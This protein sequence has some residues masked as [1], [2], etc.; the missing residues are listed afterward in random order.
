ML[1]GLETVSLGKRQ[2]SELEV[3]ELK[4]LSPRK[5]QRYMM[6]EKVTEI[7]EATERSQALKTRSIASASTNR[8]RSSSASIVAAKTCAKLEAVRAKAEFLKKESEILIEKARLKVTE[9][10][11][12]ASLSALKHESEVAAALAEAKVLE[13]AAESELGERISDVRE[14]S[15]RTHDY[16][17]CQSQVELS[18]PVGDEPYQSP[19]EPIVH[20]LKPETPQRQ[21]SLYRLGCNPDTGLRKAWERLEDCFGSPEIIEKSLFDR[22][23]SFPKISNKDA[24]KLRELR[25]LL[26]EVESAKRKGYNIFDRDHDEMAPPLREGQECWYLPIFGVYHPQKPGQ[27]RVVFDSSVQKQGISLNDVLLSG[28]DLNNSLLGVLLRFRRE[29]VAVT[30]DIEQMFHSFIVKEEDRDF[31]HFLWF[32]ENDTRKEIIEYCM[33]AH[34]FG[35][36][37]SPA[38]AIYGLRQAAAYDEKEYGSDAKHFVEREFYVDDGLLSTPTAAEAIDL[39]TRT[40]EMLA[41]LNLRLHKFASNSKE[42]MDAFP[43]KDHA[44]GLKDLNLEV[45]PTPI[46]C[47]LGLSSD[48]KRDVFTFHVTNIKKPFTRRGILATVNS[49]F[50]PIGFVAPS[51]L[52]GNSYYEN[53]QVRLLTGTLLS[54]KI[55]KK[56]GM[57]GEN[58]YKISNGWKFPDRMSILP[59][60][61]L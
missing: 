14:I 9:A 51:S 29:L 23:D 12:E 19:L 34:V 7:E 41:T 52:K 8:S 30:A 43:I 24:K 46:Q 37:P 49:L 32:K 50:G 54:L 17:M 36:S 15:D 4:M 61:Q 35:N 21:G 33:R 59:S 16:V 6:A 13:A 26:Q 47:S 3:A 11:M 42:V 57:H 56:H 27:I 25:D 55:R 45:D 18:P 39:L 40:K 5:N 2:E 1:Y 38:V 20:M 22:I 31:L 44:K 58:P 10:C 28:P 53:S 60:L 48:V